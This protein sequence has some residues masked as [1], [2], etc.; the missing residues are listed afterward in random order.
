LGGSVT[1]KSQENCGG[2]QV[3]KKFGRAHPSKSQEITE[4]SAFR[5]FF[6]SP[7]NRGK[8]QKIQI[9]KP[10]HRRKTAMNFWTS[11]SF[12][13]PRHRGKIRVPRIVLGPLKI[14]RNHGKIQISEAPFSQKFA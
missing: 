2:V 11:P 13:I 9:T 4:K 14:A 8:P 3:S 5:E 10:V 1:S 12:K 6:G 7:K